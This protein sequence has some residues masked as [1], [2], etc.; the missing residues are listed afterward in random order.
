[1]AYYKRLFV[2]L[3]L[4]SCLLFVGC[5]NGTPFYYL[6]FETDTIRVYE[7]YYVDFSCLA[8][9]S[10]VPSSDIVL[11]ASSD[12]LTFDGLTIFASKSGSCVLS[13]YRRGQ[14]D[15]ISSIPVIVLGEASS[16]AQ[17]RLDNPHYSFSYSR[18]DVNDTSYYTIEVFNDG[19]GCGD[20]TSSCSSSTAT[21]SK[22]N[23]TLYVSSVTNQSFTICIISAKLDVIT[24]TINM[25]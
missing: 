17:E 8:Y 2:F 6:Y 4:F 3:L 18:Q 14:S 15:A 12:V 19:V 24:V 9:E 21:I 16:D 23:H 11:S 13:V 5:D 22:M 10:N 25:Y 1:M 20:F 7:G